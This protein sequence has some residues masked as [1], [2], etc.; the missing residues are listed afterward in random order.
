M[1]RHWYQKD[2]PFSVTD[3]L[4]QTEK[5]SLA[6][7]SKYDFVFALPFFFHSS[8]LSSLQEDKKVQLQ[9]EPELVFHLKNILKATKLQK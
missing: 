9:K 2:I 8:L 6:N 1:F 3:L 5:P 7:V 4:A